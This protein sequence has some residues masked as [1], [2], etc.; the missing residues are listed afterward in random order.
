MNK[1]L[2]IM[3]L[4]VAVSFA[5]SGYF[6]E[7]M[8]DK[9]ASHWNASGNVDGYMSKDAM[10]L[11]IPVMNAGLLLLFTLIPKI[12]PLK[13][14]IGKFRDYYDNFI[15]IILAFMAYI[16]FMTIIWNLGYSY[17][18]NFVVIPGVAALFYYAGVLMEHSEK[19]WF[20]GMRTPWTMS[21][22][23]V[24]KK[25]NKLAGKVFKASAFMFLLL[26]LLP[27]E[28]M[29]AGVLAIIAVSFYPVIYSYFEYQKEARE[30]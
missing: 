16:H 6:Y 15:M 24:W 9:M 26:L 23:K 12:D 29:L 25:S 17:N 5:L 2:L 28:F 27:A 13:K 18:M 21:S 1:K 8:P 19:N 30:K 14:N 22:E 10:M 3:L 4:I 7:Q 11:F 20:I